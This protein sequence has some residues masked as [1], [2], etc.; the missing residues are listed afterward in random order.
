MGDP[1]QDKVLQRD[2]MGQSELGLNGSFAWA[3]TKP[4]SVFTVCYTLLT[5]H[6]AIPIKLSLEQVNIE[7]QLVSCI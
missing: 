4:K 3:C 5:L 6:G 2:L 7:L 1:T